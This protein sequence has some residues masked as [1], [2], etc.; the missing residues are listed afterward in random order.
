MAAISQE[1]DLISEDINGNLYF[2][3]SGWIYKYDSDGNLINKTKVT[4]PSGED[5]P[6]PYISW[7]G[8]IYQI[9]WESNKLEEGFKLIRW[10]T[11]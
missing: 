10:K 3:V 2:L 9:F 5:K 1:G 11:Q 7:N 4:I 6:I 8:D